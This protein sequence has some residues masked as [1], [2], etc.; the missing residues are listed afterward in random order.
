M[1]NG[2]SGGACVLQ[3]DRGR[4]DSSREQVVRGQWPRRARLG[5]ANNV[6]QG[7]IAAKMAEVLSNTRTNSS[8][9]P[10]GAV[11]VR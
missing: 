2:G 6:R 11:G 4:R 3:S 9:V 10:S 1:D 5:K 8:R 7:R